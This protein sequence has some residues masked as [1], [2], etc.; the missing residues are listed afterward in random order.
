VVLSAAPW[1]DVGAAYRVPEGSPPGSLSREYFDAT[2][3]KFSCGGLSL[4]VRV[5]YHGD[6]YGLNFCLRHSG[7]P[8]VEFYD[9]DY[10]YARYFLGNQTE[11]IAAEAP[12]LGQFITRYYVETILDRHP[13]AGLSLH[14]GEPKWIVSPA[15]M[16]DIQEWLRTF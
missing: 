12:K 9:T 10:A 7:D 13:Q 4:L 16:R 8:L 6:P 1:R 14:G 15:C 3:K 5:V 11:A 2:T